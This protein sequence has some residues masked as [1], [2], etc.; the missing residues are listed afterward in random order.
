M[1]APEQ[2]ED[3][4]TTVETAMAKTSVSENSRNRRPTTPPM[5]MS[6]MKAQ[7]KMA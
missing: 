1:A 5:K 7:Q 4:E 6:G 2:E 3:R